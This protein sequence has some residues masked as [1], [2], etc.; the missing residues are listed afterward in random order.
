MEKEM[1]KRCRNELPNALLRNCWNLHRMAP[2]NSIPRRVTL[3]QQVRSFRFLV[4]LTMWGSADWRHQSQET[5]TTPVSCN[6]I[7]DPSTR[8][9]FFQSC[10]SCKTSQHPCSLRLTGI[11]SIV[12]IVVHFVKVRCSTHTVGPHPDPGHF[13]GSQA[14]QNICC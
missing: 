12:P 13:I 4:F 6:E 11:I 5:G 10:Q 8:Q 14:V 9:G 1:Q 7:A 3:F 2:G